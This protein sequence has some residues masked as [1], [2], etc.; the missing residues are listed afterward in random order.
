MVFTN[1]YSEINLKS[2]YVINFIIHENFIINETN[3]MVRWVRKNTTNRT[4]V[5]FYTYT[6]FSLYISML[7]LFPKGFITSNFL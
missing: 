7:K 6:Y 1:I 3:Y 2:T 4:L 5:V